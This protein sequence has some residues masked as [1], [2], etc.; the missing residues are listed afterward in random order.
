MSTVE[1]AR[2]VWLW[3]SIYKYTCTSFWKQSWVSL[4]CPGCSGA[5]E[6]HLWSK[7]R[8]SEMPLHQEAGNFY[9][10]IYITFIPKII[11]PSLYNITILRRVCPQGTL[12]WS[13]Q[14]TLWSVQECSALQW[15]QGNYLHPSTVSTH[16]PVHR[17]CF[18]SWISWTLLQGSLF[19]DYDVPLPKH[20]QEIEIIKIILCPAQNLMGNP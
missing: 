17:V 3:I 11:P 18:S 14:D 15:L 2:K 13:S 7:Q 12:E 19:C 4:P 1:K 20:S 9:N 8:W 16:I 5:M 10:L 6:Q